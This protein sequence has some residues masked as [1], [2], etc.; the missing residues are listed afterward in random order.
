LDGR[1][2]TIYF[3]IKN[4]KEKEKDNSCKKFDKDIEFNIIKSPIKC[5]ID[6]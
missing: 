4:K 5:V 6:A 3:P 1:L 2:K